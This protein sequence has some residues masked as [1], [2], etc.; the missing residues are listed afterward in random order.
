MKA[1]VWS[2][3]NCPQCDSAKKLLESR[4]IEIEERQIGLGYT[5]EDLLDLVP[6]ARSV[7][8][9]FIDDELV[10]GFSELQKFLHGND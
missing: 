8:Q 9:I 2:K 10:G 3:T 7:P 1:I 4:D 6:D 5:K